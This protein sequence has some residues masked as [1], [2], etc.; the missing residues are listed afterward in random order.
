VPHQIRPQ[1]ILFAA[2][3]YSRAVRF[4]ALIT[5]KHKPFCR[6]MHLLGESLV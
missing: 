2:A 4:I 5:K 3:T 1:I 6:L